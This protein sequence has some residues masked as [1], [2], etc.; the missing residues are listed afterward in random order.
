M[1]ARTTVP[2]PVE[3]MG[4][5][6]EVQRATSSATTPDDEQFRLWAEHALASEEIEPVRKGNTLAIRIVDEEEGRRFNRQYRGKDY[7][8]NVLSFP[9]DLPEG[10]PS[11]I[12]QAQLGDLLICAPVVAREARQQG[13]PE[14]SHW[15]HLTV[16]GVLHLLGYDHEQG[17]DVIAM[18]T[19]EIDILAKLDIPDPYRAKV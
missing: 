12:K 9:V 2:M 16:H 7:A 18:E 13:K 1:P 17:A 10:L 4:V 3:P 15:A 5:D 19:L 6:L 8:T 14:I 11:G